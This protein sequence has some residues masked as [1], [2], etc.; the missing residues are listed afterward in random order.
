MNLISENYNWNNLYNEWLEAS[1]EDTSDKRRRKEI[2]ETLEDL[3]KWKKVK[4][5][6]S[7]WEENLKVN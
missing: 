1:K 3:W 7:S 4:D 5:W 2:V 6:N